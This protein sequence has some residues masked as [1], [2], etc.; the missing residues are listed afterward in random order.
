LVT[1]NCKKWGLR[2]AGSETR[3]EFGK[4]WINELTTL[5]VK[6]PYYK[7]AS[8]FLFPDAKA[9]LAPSKAK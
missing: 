3:G 8:P 6:T 2:N 7:K 1:A 9:P 5:A 4:G